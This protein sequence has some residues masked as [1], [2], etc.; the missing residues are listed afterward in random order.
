MIGSFLSMLL[1]RYLL[2]RIIEKKALRVRI[3][4]AIDKALHKEGL[5]FTLLLRLCPL[6]PF[7][8]LNYVLGITS[9]SVKNF[10][11]GGFGMIPGTIT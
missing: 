4:K 8:F 2:R 6:I 7:S 1:G 10:L 5:K 3:F 9:V 11:L